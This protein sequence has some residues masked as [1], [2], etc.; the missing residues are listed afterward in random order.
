MRPLMKCGHSQNGTTGEKPACALCGCTEVADVQP[1]LAGRKARCSYFGLKCKGE[2]ESSNDL[3]FFKHRPDKPY[4]EY[5]CG[6]YGW[7]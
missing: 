5:Y 1:D 7:N 2:R 4:D 6:C 3:P